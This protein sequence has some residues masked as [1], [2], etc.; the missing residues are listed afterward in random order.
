MSAA[1]TETHQRTHRR[2]LLFPASV[3]AIVVKRRVRASLLILLAL[4]IAV[5][6]TG[7]LATY[8]LYRSAEDRYIGVVLPLRGL[9]R[10]V[11][12][13]MEREESGVRGYIITT[14][15]R[16]LVPYFEGRR[17]VL[18]DLNR[19]RALTRGRDL[20]GVDLPKIRRQAVA[21]HGFYD[22][23][24]VF[25]A[26]GV[27]GQKR[28]RTEVLDGAVLAARFNRSAALMQNGIDRFAQATR[29]Q[30]RTTLDRALA[31]LIV[32]GFLALAVAATLL[33]KVPER[34][35]RLYAS[36]EDA[37][38]RAEQGANAARA[39][40]HVSDAVLLVDDGGIIRFWN[41]AGEQLFGIT[42]ARALGR[43]ADALVPD[44]ARLVEAAHRQDG[45]VPVVIDESER[46]LSPA[47]SVF[48]GGS[49]LAVRDATEGYVLERARA[50]FVAT[51]SHELRT[52]LTAVYGGARTL[53]T[54]GG[55]LSRG[56]Q[57]SLLQMIEQESEHLVQIVDQLLIS[58]QLD[59][60]ALHLDVAECDVLALCSGVIESARLRA[61][62]GI[63]V[64]F[65]APTTM[66]PLRCDESLLRQVL[67]NLVENALK[68]SVDGGQV[69]VRLR[70][71]PGRVRIDVRDQ[72]L[73]IPPVEQER[74]F[75]KFYRL[76][77]AMSRG[78]GGSGLGL[79]ISREIVT[80]LGGT[81]S[82][83]S[84]EGAGSTFSV[85]LP[86]LALSI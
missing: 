62:A 28:A 35:R 31:V 9:T 4:L 70:D 83:R 75:E 5:L 84:V 17:L 68:Y 33:A 53:L 25:V 66:E 49:V 2:A 3:P 69:D 58:A 74:I 11:A 78:V 77:A 13:Q 45:F 37:R 52:P 22:R 51:A 15:R 47:L 8:T 85:A 79:F 43:N 82:V 48:E 19:I 41:E 72:G 12:V 60:G 27:V 71:E 34:L 1:A 54:H 59:R 50:D 73:G 32:A 16:S 86:R 36:E 56:Q 42:E 44:Y 76:D 14:D 20:P 30:Q 81:L 39:L 65:H 24:I 21:L 23:L 26:D 7:M 38:V 40:A 57:S 64:T 18:A 67:V 46:W 29:D 55:R 10:D 6:A 63:L 61:P 80:Q